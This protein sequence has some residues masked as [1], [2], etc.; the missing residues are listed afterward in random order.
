ML[1]GGFIDSFSYT[2]STGLSTAAPA[3]VAEKAIAAIH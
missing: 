2:L 1:L 3:A